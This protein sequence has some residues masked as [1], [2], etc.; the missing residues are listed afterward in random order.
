MGGGAGP[1]LA[2]SS[3]FFSLSCVEPLQA[4]REKNAIPRR[5]LDAFDCFSFNLFPPLQ[6]H[7]IKFQVFL[8]LSQAP[9]WKN[10]SKGMGLSLVYAKPIVLILAHHTSIKNLHF[11]QGTHISFSL[12]SLSLL[13]L[14]FVLLLL[15]SSLSSSCFY[16]V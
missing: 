4:A 1:F 10:A 15:S 14:S 2:S 5:L 3:Y 12:L 7:T 16:M 6:T 13:I 11:R 9:S 8:P